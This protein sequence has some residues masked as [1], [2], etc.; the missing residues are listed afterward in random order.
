MDKQSIGKLL[1]RV[2]LGGLLLFHG[3]DKI[4]HGITFI[5]NHMKILELP[6]Y[7]AYG[8]YIGEIVAPILLILGWYS[9]VWAT[10]IAINMSVAIYLVHAKSIFSLSSY[11]SW[12]M[13]TPMLFLMSALAILFL[14][15]GNYAVK[16]D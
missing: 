15:S 16:R 4:A 8:V 7:I 10:I 5:E 12:A 3:V 11:G 2:M 14:G 6:T 9:R 13:E 1:L